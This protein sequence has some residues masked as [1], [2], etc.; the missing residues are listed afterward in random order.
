M[1]IGVKPGQ[2]GWS[3]QELETSWAVAEEAG[4]DLLSCFDHVTAAPAGLAAWDAPSLLTAM[5]ARTRRIG[6]AVHVINASLR[7]PLLL[8]A[9]LAVAQAAGGGRLEVGLGAGSP[10]LAKF[11]HLATG[12][13][14]P[15][16][17][18][19]LQR[20][21][22]CCRVLPALWRGET[23]TVDS[24]GLREASL[25]PLGIDPPPIVVG[26]ISD[27]VIDIAARHAEGWNAG[28][29]DPDAFTELSRRLDDA[30]RRLG[31]AEIT[32]QVQLFARDVRPA[33][34]R[35]LLRRFEDAGAG[36]AVIV[37][38]EERGPDAVRRLADAIL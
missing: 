23:V 8:A 25:G 5:A 27:G 10:H 35:S 14:F 26:G 3:F 16:L 29:Q 21:E 33:G 24:L 7:H 11:D 28:S 13:P 1:R 17:P 36:T 38:H 12:I 2:W 30:C 34:L 19:R 6:L 15:S 22:A 20:L 9:Q 37:L 31:R 32:R 18:E 4:F